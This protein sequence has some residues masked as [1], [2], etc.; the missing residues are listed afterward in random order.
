MRG[1]HQGEFRGV[2]A[3]GPAVEYSSTELY[4][5]ADGLLAEEWIASDTETLMSRLSGS[6]APDPD[7]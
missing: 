5:I 4:R 1:T 2:P 7:A 6:G 3:T